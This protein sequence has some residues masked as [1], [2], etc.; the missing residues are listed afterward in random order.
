MIYA[1]TA[2]YTYSLPA[3]SRRQDGASRIEEAAAVYTDAVGIG[4]NDRSRPAGH[5]LRAVGRPEVTSF[6]MTLAVPRFIW[7]VPS[8][9]TTVLSIIYGQYSTV[10][11]RFLIRC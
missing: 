11:C 8:P 10:L 7:G 6:T 4:H 1:A 5:P 9:V 3:P 2:A